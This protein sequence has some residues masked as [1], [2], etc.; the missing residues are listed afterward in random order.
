[1][2]S[3]VCCVWRFHSNTDKRAIQLPPRKRNGW[4]ASA[5]LTNTD[6]GGI[7]EGYG[8]HGVFT[9]LPFRSR[10]EQHN[11]MTFPE[12]VLPLEAVKST[13]RFVIAAG[14]EV[15]AEC[16]NTPEAVR[17]FAEYSARNSSQQAAIYRRAASSWIKY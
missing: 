2:R 9:P 4:T 12:E 15:I 7:G 13:A 16:D 17:A 3:G 1:M 6:K 5:T 11:V 14:G 10:T 8:Q